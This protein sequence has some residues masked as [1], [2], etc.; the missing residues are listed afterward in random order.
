MDIVKS[1]DI[2]IEVTCTQIESQYKG[3]SCKVWLIS[4]HSSFKERR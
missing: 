1:V 2:I 4:Q 3:R